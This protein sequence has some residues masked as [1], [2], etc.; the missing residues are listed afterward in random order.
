[1][2]TQNYCM[3]LCGSHKKWHAHKIIWKSELR[4]LKVRYYPLFLCGI[5]QRGLL[6]NYNNGNS[7]YKLNLL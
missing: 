2:K 7:N 3:M 4:G 1:M 5:G 6:A